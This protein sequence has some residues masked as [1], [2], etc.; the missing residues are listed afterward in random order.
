MKTLTPRTR[1]RIALLVETSRSY[2]RELLRGIARFGG[3]VSN[4]TLLHQEMSIDETLPQ[5]VMASKVQGVIARVDDH[6]IDALR[7]LRVP[8]VD[9]RCSKMFDGVP[10]VETDDRAVARLAFEHLRERGFHR[11]AYCGFPSAHYSLNRLEYFGEFV[12]EA[13]CGLAV[14]TS[15]DDG[16][17]SLSH[18]E[19]SGIMESEQLVHWLRSLQPPTGIFVCNDIRGQQVLNACQL[20]TISVPDELAVIGVDN[21]DAIC[22]L[23][24]PPLSSVHPNAEQV[25]YRAAEILSGMLKGVSPSQPIEYIP[26]RK[27]IPR[28]STQVSAVDDREVARLC[29]FIREHA[30]EGI[31]VVD[32]EQSSALSRRQLERRFR[33]ELNRSIHD[34]I[35]SSQI[36]RVK[37]LLVETTLSLDGIAQLAGYGHKEQLSTVFKRE[38]G[39]TPGQFRR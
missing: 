33:K 16:S 18:I 23:C 12:K 25:G 3:T 22:S 34:E 8:I 17:Q 20:A 6:N 32:V 36:A 29:H 37:Q 11:F 21:D 27:V 26:P 14:Y 39:Q 5:W 2:G 15:H 24:A 28:L 7:T 31:K 1:P 38:T 35:T 4:W 30:C 10:Q 19:R 9:V 13:G